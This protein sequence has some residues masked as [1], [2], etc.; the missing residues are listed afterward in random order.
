M[1]AVRGNQSEAARRLGIS[2]NTLIERLARYGI[3]PDLARPGEHLRSGGADPAHAPEAETPST[4]DRYFRRRPSNAPRLIP[5]RRAA[6][7]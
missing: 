4:R 7:E 2:R 5:R 6:S 3:A 1:T